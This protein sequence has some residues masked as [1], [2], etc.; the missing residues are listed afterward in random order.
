MSD[1]EDLGEP[2]TEEE[3]EARCAR[4]IREG[5][6][7]SFKDLMAALAEISLTEPDPDE[8]LPNT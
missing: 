8:E 3:M 5:R 7:P 1:T 4:L 6:M 2:M